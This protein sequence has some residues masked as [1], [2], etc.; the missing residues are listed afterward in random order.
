MT[1]KDDLVTEFGAEGRQRKHDE[2]DLQ[3]AVVEYLR[4]ALPV[5]A[6]HWAVPNGGKRHRREAARMVRLG[7]R[8]GIPDLHLAYKGR[9][10]C[11]ELKTPAGRLNEAQKQTIPKLVKCGVPV[12]V[13]TS[14][15]EV[16]D[17][18]DRWGI[19]RTASLT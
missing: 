17:A 2:D 13:C 11:I 10:Y 6:L 5:D 4:W 3:G 8:A 12:E 14:L 19:P 15:V 1:Y 9:L 16:V 18:L 7:V